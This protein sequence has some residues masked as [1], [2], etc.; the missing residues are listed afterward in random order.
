MEL[1]VHKEIMSWNENAF[2]FVPNRIFGSPFMPAKD[3]ISIL[4]DLAKGLDYLHQE[5]GIVHR[6]IKPQNIL[7]CHDP[8]A[9]NKLTAKFC[10]FG[11]SEKL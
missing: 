8:A 1:A 10:D 5:A 7:L 6:D 2:C 11:V 3:I 4:H 9:P